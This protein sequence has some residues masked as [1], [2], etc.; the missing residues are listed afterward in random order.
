M[1]YNSYTSGNNKIITDKDKDT[2]IENNSIEIPKSLMDVSQLT[3][4]VMKL[5]N[6]VGSYLQQVFNTAYTNGIKAGYQVGYENGKK[7]GEKE[8]IT[9]G[10]KEGM[11][12]G[13]KEAKQEANHKYNIL[14]SQL[15][16]LKEDKP[17][18]RNRNCFS[19]SLSLEG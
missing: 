14:F 16:E 2:E 3:G 11:K 6:D 12:L 7:D 5:S 18:D 10:K 19:N 17:F 15:S 13:F 8:G 1:S 4:S 9:I